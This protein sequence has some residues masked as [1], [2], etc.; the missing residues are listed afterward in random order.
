MTEQFTFFWNGPFSQWHP[1]VFELSGRTF[2]CAEQWMMFSKALL[3]DDGDIIDKIMETDDPRKQ[4]SLGRI[5][6]NFN[7]DHW[8]AVARDIVICGNMAKFT[9][10]DDLKEI[11]IQTKGTTLVEASPYDKIWGIGLKE[12]DPRALNR[13]TWQGTNWLGE[14]LTVV[15]NSI[16]L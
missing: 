16:L 13:E 9:Q 10:N 8:N 15:R 1:S 14:A 3:F 4:K 12:N 5:V 6:K 11:L 7:S 2:T